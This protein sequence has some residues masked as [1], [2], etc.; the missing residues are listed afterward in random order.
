MA[1]WAKRTL[2]WIVWPPLGVVVPIVMALAIF[3]SWIT[4]LALDEATII[5]RKF[6]G[7]TDQARVSPIANRSETPGRA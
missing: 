6:I 1:P 7:R 4:C 2:E 3:V 5:L